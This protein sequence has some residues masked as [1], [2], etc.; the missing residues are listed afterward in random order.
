MRS[1][2]ANQRGVLAIG[3]G[4][5]VLIVFAY[6]VGVF[7]HV[8]QQIGDLFI[9]PKAPPIPVLIVEV[10]E[11]SIQAIGQW[12]WRRSVFAQ[13]IQSLQD[14]RVIGIDVALKEPSRY[15]ATDDQ[16]L[17]T[18]FRLSKTPVVLVSQLIDGE[19]QKPL[20][21]SVASSGY[22]N[23]SIDSDGVVRRL[24]LRSSVE[25]SF[26]QAVA[27]KAGYA[28]SPTEGFIRFYGSKRTF[29]HV[30]LI[31]VLSKQVDPELIREA[32]VLIGA[33]AI[34]LQDIRQ[35]PVGIMSGVEI[36]ATL[37]SNLVAGDSTRSSGLLDS[38]S[39][40]LLGLL[41][42]GWMLSL[43]RHIVGLTMGVAFIGAYWIIA[44]IAFE[45]G[46]RLDVLYPTVA[47]VTGIGLASVVHYARAQ[48]ERKFIH[49]TF[50]R[51]VSRDIISQL[52]E[53]PDRVRLGG[54]A[55]D[56]TILFSDIRG[57]TTLSES[58]TPER[59]VELLNMY[60][61]AMTKIILQNNGVVDKYIGDAIMAFWGDPIDNPRHARDAVQVARQM[62]ER[63]ATLNDEL[64][65]RGMPTL[66][67][68]I[69]INSGLAVAGNMGS[70]QRFDYTVMGDEVNLASRLEGLTKEYKIG[71]ICSQ[72]VID[73]LPSEAAKQMREIDRVRVKG[74]L[75]AVSIYTFSSV[76]DSA[77]VLGRDAYYAGN[78]NDAIAH[79]TV[80]LARVEHDG[81]AGI[82]LDRA[83]EFSALPPASWSG[84]YEMKHK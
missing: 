37:V 40:V 9:T 17:T 73:R 51:Y 69:G 39:I 2:F 6:T 18:T 23:I 10:D 22:A 30:S 53:H 29:D 77:F 82:L 50:A 34:D 27:Q 72:N 80:H 44:F 74:K 19:L 81:P 54:H 62:I 31:D 67:I 79:L 33:T 12:P 59:L 70:E 71:L 57:F 83:K 26:A 58:L 20:F 68:G 47:G 4:A 75:T 66:S 61:D 78:W 45:Q 32:I 7:K 1:P 3:A 24:S 46:V 11:R 64:R 56:M 38:M 15:G 36:Q 48:G 35:T 8:S 25:A 84:A 63:L 5:L 21:A 16:A 13:V 28:T 41:C 14:A 52:I 55:K 42:F 76:D 65:E 60:L 43:S 49:D